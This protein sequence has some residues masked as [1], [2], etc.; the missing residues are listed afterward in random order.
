VPVEWVEEVLVAAIVELLILAIAGL[1]FGAGMGA[2]KNR[3]PTGL[4]RAL[5]VLSGVAV[6]VAAVAL[7]MGW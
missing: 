3:A 1:A 2:A 7:V 5:F 6:A 4:V